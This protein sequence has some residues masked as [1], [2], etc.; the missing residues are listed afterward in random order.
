M[1][2]G[3][4][5]AKAKAQAQANADQTGVTW[6]LWNHGGTWW[7]ERGTTGPSSV[8][9]E[10][11]K[12]GGGRD[13]A[14]EPGHDTNDIPP[15]QPPPGFTAEECFA[16]AEFAGD[17]VLKRGDS[18]RIVFNPHDEYDSDTIGRVVSFDPNGPF[19]TGMAY[20]Q[21]TSKRTGK[22]EK[23]PFGVKNLARA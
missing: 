10:I 6:V 16:A 12:P 1:N 15:T 4:D 5:Y 14:A 23:L 13:H 8:D 21:Y 22:T 9:A 2:A 11:F 19:G 7:I 3:R 17:L 18:V 20:V